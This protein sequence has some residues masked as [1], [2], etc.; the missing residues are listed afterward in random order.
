MLGGFAFPLLILSLGKIVVFG[1]FVALL[2]CLALVS[3]IG[4]SIP[5]VNGV[6]V[7]SSTFVAV[8]VIFQMRLRWS[9]LCIETL[10]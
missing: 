4:W 9:A 3:M 2:W 6:V 8:F 7:I 10:L 5:M 1:L